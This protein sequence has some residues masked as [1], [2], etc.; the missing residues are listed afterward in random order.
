MLKLIYLKYF[1]S[2]ISNNRIKV[3]RQRHGHM[4]TTSSTL[5]QGWQYTNIR[6]ENLPPPR[7][8]LWYPE[9]SIGDFA[10]NEIGHLYE[11]F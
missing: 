9:H 8:P 5:R 6:N 10:F 1:S 11:I 7:V 4:T 3:N 2:N